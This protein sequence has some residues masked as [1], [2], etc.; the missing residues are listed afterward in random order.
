MKYLRE[1]YPAPLGSAQC[2]ASKRALLSSH[3]SPWPHPTPSS[4]TQQEC[5]Q[6]S[7][8]G[9]FLKVCRLP[10]NLRCNLLLSGSNS[11][12]KQT[13]HATER[14]AVLVTMCEL[15]QPTH[16]LEDLHQDEVE[17]VDKR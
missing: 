4:S 12:R 5:V 13:N 3:A 1:K 10:C 16:L 8:C 7:V 11:Q 2:K 6:T 9:G 15:L 17:L 14:W